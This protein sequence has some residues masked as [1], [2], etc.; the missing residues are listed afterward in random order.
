[1]KSMEQP[2]QFLPGAE[3]KVDT[4][5]KRILKGED[6][7]EVLQGLGATFRDAV[8][9]KKLEYERK[10]IP[11]ETIPEKPSSLQENQQKN[12]DQQK[13]DAI[14]EELQISEWSSE[15]V[16]RQ[17]AHYSEPYMSAPYEAVADGS[18]AGIAK[19]KIENGSVVLIRHAAD[20]DHLVKKGKLATGQEMMDSS[21]FSGGAHEAGAVHTSADVTNWLNQYD[22]YPVYGEFRIPVKDFLQL[23]K[24][25]KIIIGNLGEAE[26]VLSG[27]VAKKY[28][29]QVFSKN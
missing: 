8:E 17:L 23:G 21:L 5:T 29:T 14:E 13:I 10:D 11:T 6:P 7:A 27:D 25:G 3:E 19:L 22:R 24:E 15:D 28:L 1:M 12:I 2:N 9:K 18:F 26:I 4:Y 20:E 16:L